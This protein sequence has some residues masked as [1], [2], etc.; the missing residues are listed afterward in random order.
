MTTQ[1]FIGFGE[2]LL[3][4]SVPDRGLLLQANRLDLHVGGAEAN[5]CVALARLGHRTRMISVLPANDLGMIAR[6]TLASAGVDVR[7]RER[8]LIGN[9]RRRLLPRRAMGWPIDG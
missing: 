8:S 2:V 5:V 9:L 7:A 3:R 4:L 1:P 6:S